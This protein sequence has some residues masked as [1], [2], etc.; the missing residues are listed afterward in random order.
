MLCLPGIKLACL[1]NLSMLLVRFSN[2]SCSKDSSSPYFLNCSF[3]FAMAEEEAQV[4]VQQLGKDFC[5][6]C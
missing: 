1:S 5:P 3:L 2:L 6:L 4:G